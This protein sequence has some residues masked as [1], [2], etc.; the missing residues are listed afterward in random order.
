MKICFVGLEIIPIKGGVVLGGISS[1][2]QLSKGLSG[3]GHQVLILTS[4]VNR[5]CHGTLSEPWGEIHPH[6]VHGQYASVRSSAEF[7]IKVIP[8]IIREYHQ[9]RFDILHFFSSYPAFGLISLLSR[10]VVR[11][12]KVFTLDSP[13]PPKPLRDRKGIYQQLSSPFWSRLFL[14]GIKLIAINQNVKRSLISTGFNESAIALL[15]P[16]IDTARFNARLD[17]AP[18][19]A[20]LKVAQ[21]TPLVL[22]CGNWAKWKGIDILLESMVGVVRELPGVRLI[23]AWGEAYDWYDERRKA[24]SQKIKAWHLEKNII[25]LGIIPDMERLMAASD[26]F[27]APF[28]NTDGVVD[29]PVSILEAMSCATPVIATRVGGIPEIVDHKQNGLLVPPGNPSE[30][31][32]AILYLL[33]NRSESRRM[34]VKG[35]E[36]V[37]QRFTIEMV[38]DRLEEIYQ[39]MIKG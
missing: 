5:V 27:V 9:G 21:E 37:S 31:A 4:D 10:A 14:S 8:S 6:P 16:A 26:V 13:I 35:A 38:V 7:V 29:S 11:V 24:I 34:G 25:E 32:S 20:E 12:P 3:R 15:P 18:K 22:Y 2:V 17:P 23:T 28:L 19:R 30:L 33:K 39:E 36:L 1:V